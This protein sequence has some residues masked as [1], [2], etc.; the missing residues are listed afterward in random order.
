[1]SIKMSGSQ[2]ELEHAACEC[3]LSYSVQEPVHNYPLLT[4]Y[5]LGL[6]ARMINASWCQLEDAC[7]LTQSSLYGKNNQ[8]MK[9]C[10]NGDGKFPA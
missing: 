3:A 9:F 2:E 8:L 10:C 6:R 5:D 4:A 7:K 1:M